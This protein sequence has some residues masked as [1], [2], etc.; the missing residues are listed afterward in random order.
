LKSRLHASSPRVIVG[1]IKFGKMKS[2]GHV[3]VSF[4]GRAHNLTQQNELCAEEDEE[5]TE[6]LDKTVTTFPFIYV[7]IRSRCSGK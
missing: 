7:I 2:I 5:K 1:A 4:R 3:N 6:R